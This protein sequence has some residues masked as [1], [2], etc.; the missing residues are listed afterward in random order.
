[1]ETT[2]SV[3][4]VPSDRLD[5]HLVILNKFWDEKSPRQFWKVTLWLQL[6]VFKLDNFSQIIEFFLKFRGGTFI[7]DAAT[8]EIFQYFKYYWFGSLL[9]TI[10]N[11]RN[12][13]LV[14]W[15]KAEPFSRQII[16]FEF[17]PTWSCIS[18]TQSTNSSTV[19]T[20]DPCTH[21]LGGYKV[22]MMGKKL[23]ELHYKGKNARVVM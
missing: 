1:M 23:S 18:L 22:K 16:Q 12:I 13:L 7:W 19:L 11:I 6:E 20:S 3:F 17:P 2:V 8:I 5:K 15:H 4:S 21:F 14:N 10:F 9:F